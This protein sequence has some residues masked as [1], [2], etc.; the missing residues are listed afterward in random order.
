MQW[1]ASMRGSFPRKDMIPYTSKPD[2]AP[3]EAA[4]EI[5]ANKGCNSQPVLA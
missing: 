2:V 4:S 3:E 1:E 5:G